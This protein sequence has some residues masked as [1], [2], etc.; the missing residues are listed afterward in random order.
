MKGYI[1]DQSIILTE[2]LPNTLKNGDEVEITIVKIQ[3]K[4]HPFSTFNLG[5]KDQYLNREKIY[6]QDLNFS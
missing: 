2:T 3:K 6:G 4:R 5:I 1:H